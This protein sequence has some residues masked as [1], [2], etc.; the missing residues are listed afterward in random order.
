MHS[1]DLRLGLWNCMRFVQFHATSCWKLAQRKHHEIPSKL[2]NNNKFITMA[3]SPNQKALQLHI[4]HFPRKKKTCRTLPE[5]PAIV[6]QPGLL[7]EVPH[8][9]RMDIPNL[10]VA[11][12]TAVCVDAIVQFGCFWFN[13]EVRTDR[14]GSPHR[15]SFRST[16]GSGDF[17]LVSRIDKER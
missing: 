4:P 6:W 7:V 2:S 11:T 10:A 14:D 16:N 1:H 12:S 17:F 15:T 5:P 3:N 9:L 13:I 8:G